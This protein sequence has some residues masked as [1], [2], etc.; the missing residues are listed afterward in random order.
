MSNKTTWFFLKN[1]EQK[2]LQLTLDRQ[3]EQ[4]SRNIQARN[5]SKPTT[6]PKVIYE[7][8]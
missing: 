4:Y 7:L 8:A 3:A 1:R 6:Q 2:H 5:Q